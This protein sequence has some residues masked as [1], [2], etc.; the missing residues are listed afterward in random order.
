MDFNDFS[1]ALLAANG[2][3]PAGVRL[4]QG[5]SAEARFAVYRNNVLASLVQALADTFPVVQALVGPPFFQA[6][7][8]DYAR[9][10]PPESP[11]LA[12]YGEGFAAF[13][14]AYEAAAPVP[15]LADVAQLEYACIRAYYAADAVAISLQEWQHLMQQAHLLPLRRVQLHPSVQCVSS[16]FSV[17]AIW[18][19]HQQQPVAPFAVAAAQSAWVFRQHQGFEVLA[20]APGDGDFLHALLAGN[21]LGAALEAV[22]GDNFDLNRCLNAFIEKQ[23]VVG[24]I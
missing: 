2:C 12:A 8:V 24:V 10:H 14:Q 13:I 4:S 21:P 15:Y 18:Q 22:Q 3:L 17:A 20:M 1:N 16:P 7:A 23:L 9:Q 6:M 11:L 5:A 19:A